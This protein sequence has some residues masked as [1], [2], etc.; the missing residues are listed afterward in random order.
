[1]QNDRSNGNIRENHPRRHEIETTKSEGERADIKEVTV[2][3]ETSPKRTE[4]STF[5]WFEEFTLEWSE[6]LIQKRQKKHR[7]GE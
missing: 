1:M 3:H 5:S 2:R 7:K 4:R 6:T